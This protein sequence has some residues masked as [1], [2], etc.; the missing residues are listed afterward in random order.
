MNGILKRQHWALPQTAHLPGALAKPSQLE[1][2]TPFPMVP[3]SVMNRPAA[4]SG[5]LSS[6]RRIVATVVGGR[7]LSSLLRESPNYAAQR[8][9]NGR[10]GLLSV[11]LHHESHDGGLHGSRPE[12]I[13]P[14]SETKDARRC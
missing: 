9:A 1:R 10:P 2:A 3:G 14:Y 11:G 4:R 7:S 12:I 5:G 13:S 8:L 6:R